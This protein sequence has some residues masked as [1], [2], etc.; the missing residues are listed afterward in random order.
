MSCLSPSQFPKFDFSKTFKSGGHFSI[1]Y[2][3]VSIRFIRNVVSFR[4]VVLSAFV[5]GCIPCGSVFQPHVFTN[6]SN[7]L[8]Y[9]HTDYVK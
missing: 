2:I 4:S 5:C 6:Y 7:A 9:S 8:W 3:Y 1:G